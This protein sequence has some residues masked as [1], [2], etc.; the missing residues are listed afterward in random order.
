MRWQW[1]GRRNPMFTI[2]VDIVEVARIERA[3]A[4][5]GDRFLRR[6]FTEAEIEYCQ[7]RAQSLASRFAAKEAVSKALGT[8][9]AAQAEHEAGWVD[10][11][12]IEVVRYASGEPT[13][14]LHHKALARAAALGIEGW[15][16]SMSHTHEHA[17]AMVLGWRR[18]AWSEPGQDALSITSGPTR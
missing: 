3:V 7:G 6:V 13:L 15:R 12:E 17:V 10:W 5:W 11:V 18:A 8:G 4:R 9:W 14:R 2:G 16:L 1:Q